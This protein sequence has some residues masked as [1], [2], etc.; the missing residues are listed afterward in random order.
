MPKKDL[1]VEDSFLIAEKILQKI[2]LKTVKKLETHLQGDY[3]SI[4]QGHGLDFKEIRDYVINDDIRNIDWNA[5]ARTGK[6]YIRVYEEERDNIVWLILDISSSMDFGSFFTTKKDIM[7]KF[8]ALIC[9]ISYKKGDKIG[10]VLF[11]KDI[12]EI[13]TPEK[14]LKQAYKIIKKLLD[15]KSNINCSN[16]GYSSNLINFSK[17]TNIIGKKKSVFFASDFIYKDCS[18]GKE[19]GEIAV[20]NKF[21][22]VHVVDPIEENIPDVGYINLYDPESGKDLVLDTSNSKITNKYKELLDAEN[23]KINEI[24]S[25]LK[26]DPVKI[27]TNSDIAEVLINYSNRR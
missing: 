24:F 12:K 17:L 18:W 10:A 5:T 21:T 19:L 3:S 9:Y 27:Y 25:V 2:T 16:Q 4:F 13:I 1:N 26:L 22:A 15:Y 7:V 8:A 20:K 23:K 6:P 11:D 14:G